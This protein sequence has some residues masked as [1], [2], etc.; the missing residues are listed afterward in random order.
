VL[1]IVSGLCACCSFPF[2]ACCFF[3]LHLLL[4]LLC[5]CC[6]SHLFTLVDVSHFEYVIWNAR[7]S[8]GY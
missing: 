3:S 6:C 5:V 7:I 1:A 8:N 2:H 4:P